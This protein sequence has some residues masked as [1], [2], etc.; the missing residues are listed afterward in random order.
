LAAFA[1]GPWNLL[2]LA[3]GLTAIACAFLLR[4]RLAWN[5]V[6][7]P[8]D[9]PCHRSGRKLVAGLV[10]I[11]IAT[12]L[13][14]LSVPV[15]RETLA[16]LAGVAGLGMVGHLDDRMRYNAGGKLVAQL[17]F[18]V[19]FLLAEPGWASAGSP[20]LLAGLA[21]FVV[22]TNGVN[23]L[24]VADGLAPGVSA[25]TLGALGFIL[26]EQGKPDFA[27]IAFVFAGATCGFLLFN[28]AP[29]RL[30]LGDAGSLPLGGLTAALVPQIIGEDGALGVPIAALLVS[31]PLFE[32]AWVS[33]RRM[34]HRVPPWVASPHHVAYWL[35]GR[36]M[37]GSQ[38]VGLMVGCHGAA[39]V[40]ALWLAGVPAGIFWVTVLLAVLAIATR[41]KSR[42]LGA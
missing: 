20:W 9:N 33:I 24:D 16:V 38:A 15:A 22:V 29:G 14:L 18:F 19:V 30:I 11:S 17:P 32:V 42:W 21:F 2:V 23:V 25:L 8:R 40:A 26:L 6:E 7:P 35:V 27:I 13:C 28:A 1:A 39:V 12:A 4:S 41:T 37:S 10:P 31:A 34:A 3:A 5:Q 36:G